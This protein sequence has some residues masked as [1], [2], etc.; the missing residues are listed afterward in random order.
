MHL[1]FLFNEGL[2]WLWFS[3]NKYLLQSHPLW[4]VL[5][6]NYREHRAVVEADAFIATLT[7]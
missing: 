2:F 4:Q 5:L 3:G 6:D 1:V 7:Q